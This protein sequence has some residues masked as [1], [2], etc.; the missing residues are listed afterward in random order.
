ME[1]NFR[2]IADVVMG[3]GRKD[4]PG[5]GKAPQP[6][7]TLPQAAPR[8]Q[9]NLSPKKRS[10]QLDEGGGANVPTP[11]REAAERAYMAYQRRNAEMENLAF[12]AIRGAILDAQLDDSYFD[13][14]PSQAEIERNEG[15]RRIKN[16]PLGFLPMRMIDEYAGPPRDADFDYYRGSRRNHRADI[17][18]DLRGLSNEEYGWIPPRDIFGRLP[19]QS[20][21]IGPRA[22]DATRRAAI[23]QGVQQGRLY[24]YTP[25]QLNRL[26]RDGRFI[27]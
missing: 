21:L 19:W 20:L 12:D 7:N 11:L 22:T 18:D 17:D 8:E 26:A 23:E 16:T 5:K 6:P 24:G 13:F 10:R 4:Q 15:R 2:N 27:P 3:G 9:E 1:L 25:E 14:G